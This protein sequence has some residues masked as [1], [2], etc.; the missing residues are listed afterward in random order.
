MADK[1]SNLVARREQAMDRADR[2]L[3]KAWPDR[4]GHEFVSEMESVASELVKTM[5]EM[6]ASGIERIEQSRTYR[7]LGSV[8]SDLAPALG[9]QMLEQAREAY[10][11]A[12][13]L[14]EGSDDVLEQAKLDFN[15]GN[16]LRQLDPNNI[17]QLQ[18]AE[19]R[20]LAARKVFAEHSPQHIP[21]A[22][23]GLSS[24]RGLLRIAPLMSEVERNRVEMENRGKQLTTSGDVEEIAGKMHEMQEQNAT[25]AGWFAEI[26]KIA[27]SLPDSARKSE[28]YQKLKGRME[29]LASL[30]R[31]GEETTDPRE[32]EMMELLRKKL[33][34][35]TEAGHVTDDR[36]KTL[37]DILDEFGKSIG[38]G[39]EDIQSLL[40]RLQDMRAK[41][42]AQLENL[43]YLSHGIDRPPA[44]SRAAEL[45]EL[46]W[47]LRRFL[48]E[49]MYRSG[50]S[51]GESKAALDLNMRA[52]DVDKRIYE[53]GSNDA[54]AAI[55]DKEALRPF[56]LR[57]R[58]FA[59][60]H[61]P[62]LV[63]PIWM[64][65]RVQ[66]DT[67]AVLFSGSKGVG[68]QVAEVCKKLQLEVISIPK[69]DDIA[70][71]RWRQ[72]QQANITI[73]DL[74]LPEGRDLAATAY[75]LGIARTLGKPVVVLASGG[76]EIPFDV[77]VEPVLLSGGV[78][79]IHALSNAID[80]SLVWTQPRTGSK[81]YLAS[82]EY[83]LS[84][85][86][87]P[88][89]DVSVDQTLRLLGDQR[90]EPDSVTINQ[91]L[92]QFV[93][94]LN[95]STTMLVHPMWPPVY[96]EAGKKRL[97][98]VMPYRPEWADEVSN[99]TRKACKQFGAAYKIGKDLEDPNVIRSIWE[100]IGKATHVL[101]DLTR[102][103]ANVALELGI[104][105][106]LGRPSLLVC[107]GDPKKEVF[108]MIA[109][110]RVYSYRDIEELGQRVGK[111]LE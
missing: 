40:T 111:F 78:E 6:Q 2:A 96:P 109:K 98:H 18:E 26:Q 94:F 20:F 57:V 80:R 21:A 63:Q 65:S 55:I 71:A 31:L 60:R 37:D 100:E 51:E 83:I 50:K 77:D 5:S 43:H 70:S 87:R 10:R 28:K 97:F 35:E 48:M 9:K 99:V 46:C 53:A 93:D 12:E 68:R 81:G 42:G 25:I 54:R 62:M 36:A 59:A 67:N 23:E 85:Y 79:D 13:D 44:G 76:Q 66:V 92:A 64:G 19:R 47:T 102:F 17:Q 32:R 108:P 72:L 69:G 24:T 61:H 82:L 33:I 90:K 7:Y 34:A 38:S 45:V 86:G 30:L 56:A 103:N 16:T 8:Y 4:K 73:F 104:V 101:V 105:Q 52:A 29:E 75:E 11:K 91:T 1:E 39:G 49:E 27:D 15:F 41:L 88:Q 107:Q 14:L 89:P 95:D 74:S 3:D 110:R 84:K 106:T 58:N 22:D